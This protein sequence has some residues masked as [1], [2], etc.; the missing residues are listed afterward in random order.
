MV[1][2]LVIMFIAGRVLRWCRVS[3]GKREHKVPVEEGSHVSQEADREWLGPTLS[4]I[5]NPL[6]RTT[7]QGHA[8]ND[9][10]TSHQAHLLSMII[11]FP[12]A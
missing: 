10:S 4:F 7:F 9:L 11:G 2:H 8:S 1:R 12:T 5:T 3:H 6:V